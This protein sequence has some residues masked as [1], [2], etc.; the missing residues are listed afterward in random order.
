MSCPFKVNGPPESPWQIPCPSLVNVQI[1]WSKTKA[2]FAAVCLARQSAF[3]NVVFVRRWS[4]FGDAPP[5]WVVP[6]HPETTVVC[7]PPIVLP[8]KGIAR[9]LVVNAIAVAVSTTDMSLAIVFAWF[10]G[11]VSQIINRKARW[12]QN[13]YIVT[14]VVDD[15]VTTMCNTTSIQSS[16]SN[17]N[18]DWVS[19]ST[20]GAMSWEN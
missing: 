10:Y 16:S 9:A 3:V 1:L 6:P 12:H 19:S 20:N 17:N 13:T 7:P 15:S 2:A 18:I 8:F 5:L 11:D 14:S 4:W